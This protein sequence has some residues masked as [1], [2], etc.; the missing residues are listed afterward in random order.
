MG[1]VGRVLSLVRHEV[2]AS[3]LPLNGVATFPIWYT[4]IV[5]FGSSSARF[6]FFLV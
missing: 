6:Q 4:H 5:L 2:R 3:L 1:F